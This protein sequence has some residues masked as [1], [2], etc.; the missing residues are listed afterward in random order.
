LLVLRACPLQDRRNAFLEVVKA[1]VSSHSLKS[2]IHLLF[3]EYAQAPLHEVIVK[4]TLM[5]LMED[6]RCDANEDVGVG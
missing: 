1:R 4:D 3:A 2:G 5:E 6:V